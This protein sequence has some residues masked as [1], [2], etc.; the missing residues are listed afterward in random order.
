MRRSR[1]P[2]SA[3]GQVLVLFAL[4]LVA[5]LVMTGLVI[6]GGNLLG[7]QRIAQNAA[8]AAAN[9]G[10]LVIAQ[11]LAGQSRTGQ[12]VLDAI[13][14]STTAN[15]LE[16]VDARYTDGFGSLLGISVSTD[17]IPSNARGVRVGGDRILETSLVRIVGFTELTASADATAVAGALSAIGRGVLPVTFPT[18]VS[19]CDG[20]GNYSAG[21]SVWPIVTID[22]RTAA[23]MA[24]IP[25]CKVDAGSVGWLDLG[26]GNLAAEI[27]DGPGPG[28]SIPIPTWLQ[29][30]TGNVNAVEDE[31]ND[32]YANS[33]VLIPMFDGTCRVDPGDASS[34]ATCPEDKRG[35]DLDPNGNGTW[36]HIPYFTTF[37]LERAY[38]A[39][40]NVN[41]CASAPGQP[42]VDPSTPGF[43]GCFKGWFIEWVYDGPIDPNRQ[44]TDD[45]SIGIQLVR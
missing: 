13:S 6:E 14:A 12:D 44:I 11:K 7:Q 10:T 21:S 31:I 9:A 34:A 4:A 27:V 8:D 28:V 41:A 39:G 17:P 23:N 3:G 24:I 22:A 16:A 20:L 45:T 40:S 18:A 5:L 26:A 35:V 1:R 42:T 36:Y 43:L 25:L 30:Q 15:G 2:D 38:V 32:N 29:T 19:A 37:W 33:P